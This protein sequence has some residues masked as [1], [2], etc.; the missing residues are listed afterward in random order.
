MKKIINPIIKA[1][2]GRSYRVFIEIEYNNGNLSLHGVEG[3]LSS[4]NCLGGC[5][6]ING[7]L[8]KDNPNEWKFTPGWNNSKVQELLNIWDRW[9]LNDMR[10]ACEHQRER[11]ETWEIAPSAVCPDCGYKLGSAWLKEEVPETVTNFLFGLPDSP[12]DPAWV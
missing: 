7:T 4:G 6:Q 8:Q 1:D 2:G 12:V 10:A 5:G 11:G 3:P 9:H